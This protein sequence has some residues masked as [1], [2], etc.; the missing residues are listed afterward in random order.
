MNT[1]TTTLPVRPVREESASRCVALRAVVTHDRLDGDVAILND[2]QTVAITDDP[3]GISDLFDAALAERAERRVVLSELATVTSAATAGPVIFERLLVAADG[4][5]V[6]V[7]ASVLPLTDHE[8]QDLQ[9]L[10]SDTSEPDLAR[11]LAAI[12]AA[13]IE[14]EQRAAAGGMPVCFLDQASATTGP[15]RP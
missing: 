8:R 4:R 13:D 10:L 12:Y 3:Q 14:Q 2:T 1:P 15:Q 11:E 5:A 6:H 9:E 7:E